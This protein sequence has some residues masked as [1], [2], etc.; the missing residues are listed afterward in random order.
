MEKVLYKYSSGLPMVTGPLKVGDRVIDGFGN[1]Y[2]VDRV[3]AANVPDLR[4]P[5][6][7][8]L[9]VEELEEDGIGDGNG[10]IEYLREKRGKRTI[11]DTLYKGAVSMLTDKPLT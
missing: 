9:N 3:G 10:L 4:I 5:R 1:F 11:F 7:M 6:Q 8:I 2:E